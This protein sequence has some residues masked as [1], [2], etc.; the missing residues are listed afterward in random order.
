MVDLE[1]TKI[2]LNNTIELAVQRERIN[3]V[4]DKELKSSQILGNYSQK[5][6]DD[7]EYRIQ[8]RDNERELADKTKGF[9]QDQINKLKDLVAAETVRNEL[10]RELSE[11][12]T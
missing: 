11:L 8:L 5:Q 4:L 3:D 1:K 9:I 6:I 12:N 7:L 10:N 2:Q